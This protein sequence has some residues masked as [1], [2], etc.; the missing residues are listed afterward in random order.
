MVREGRFARL[1]S[2]E[3]MFTAGFFDNFDDVAI[4]LV[5]VVL[6]RR[7]RR[8]VVARDRVVEPLDHEVED[9]RQEDPEEGDA[10]HPAEHGRTERPPHSEPAPSDRTSGTTPRMKANEVIMIGRS[11]R[12]QASSV[13]W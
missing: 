4:D 9:G 2:R 12:L 3:D 8:A 7:D 10:E 1:G 6:G 13:A 5:V 11:R